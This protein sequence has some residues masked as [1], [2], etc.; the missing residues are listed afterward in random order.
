MEGDLCPLPRSHE[1]SLQ[2]SQ[3]RD[4]CMGRLSHL[5]LDARQ[6][7]ARALTA[8]YLEFLERVDAHRTL[9]MMIE[10]DSRDG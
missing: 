3:L 8:E 4:W 9:W 2:I 7:D 5:S 10:Q 6:E 1:R